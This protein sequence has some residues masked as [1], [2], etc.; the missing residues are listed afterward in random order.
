MTARDQVQTFCVSRDELNVINMYRICQTSAGDSAAKDFLIIHE[1]SGKKPKWYH[2][3]HGGN[4]ME[5][6]S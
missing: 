6:I 2:V 1:K 5:A 4:N 3:S